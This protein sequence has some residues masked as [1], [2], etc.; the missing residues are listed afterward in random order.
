MICVTL[1]LTQCTPLSFSWEQPLLV[2]GSCLNLKGTEVSGGLLIAIADLG[3][4]IMP[5]PMLWSLK[6]S[7]RRKAQL[8]ALFASGVA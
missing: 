5:W 3:L 1:I 4:L 6:M 7:F 2:P 8:C